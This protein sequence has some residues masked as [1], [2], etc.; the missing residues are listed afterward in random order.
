M[1]NWDRFA[2]KVPAGT[3]VRFQYPESEQPPREGILLENYP[4]R[5]EEHIADI[6]NETRA[7]WGKEIR[8]HHPVLRFQGYSERTW[9]NFGVK[10]AEFLIDGAWVTFDQLMTED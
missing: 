5:T 10:D 9:D 8:S 3:T 4:H 7:N 1:I 2:A 6:D